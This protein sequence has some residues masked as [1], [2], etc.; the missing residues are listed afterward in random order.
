ME[1]AIQGANLGYSYSL[2][3]YSLLNGEPKR[4]YLEFPNPPYQRIQSK[5]LWNVV[6]FHVNISWHIHIHIISSAYLAM[7]WLPWIFPA[8]SL[9]LEEIVRGYVK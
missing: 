6:Y 7:E 5:N 9:Y 1:G 3:N 2:D 8:R 4:S